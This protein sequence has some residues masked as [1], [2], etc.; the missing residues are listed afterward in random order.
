MTE[1]KENEMGLKK[2][3]SITR[4]LLVAC[5]EVAVPFPPCLS[6]PLL[7]DITA[8]HTLPSIL[9]SIFNFV[10]CLPRSP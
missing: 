5:D 7:M 6:F 2:L 9:F 10:V 3:W 8:H 4:M 1:E